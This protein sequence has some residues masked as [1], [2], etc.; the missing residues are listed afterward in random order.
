[1]PDN[2]FYVQPLGG[3]DV[4]QAMDQVKDIVKQRKLE[5]AKKEAARVL[6]TEDPDQIYDFVSANPEFVDFVKQSIGIKNDITQKNLVD[7]AKNI[8]S[9]GDPEQF[10]TERVN[11]VTE[12]GGNPRNTQRA[13]DKYRALKDQVGEEEAKAQTVQKAKNDLALFAPAEYA[14]YRKALGE[15]GEKAK[16]QKTGAW[17]VKDNASG[18]Q[19]VVT[20]VFDPNTG[21]IRTEAGELGDVQLVSQLGEAPEEITQR[22]IAEKQGEVAAK[23][24]EERTTELINRGV[25]AAE[26]TAPIRRAIDLLDTVKTGG[27]ANAALRAKQLFGIESGDEGQLSNLMG[28]AVLSQLRSTFGAAFTESEGKRLMR[29]EANFGKSPETNRKLLKQALS[30]AKMTA[31][32]AREAA[33]KRGDMDTVADIDNLLTFSLSDQEQT[34]LKPVDSMSQEEAIREFLKIIGR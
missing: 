16:F 33:R 4:G 25:T 32:R 2:P 28:K 17:L 29:I 34:A 22:K 30:V 21:K 11:I 24:Q 8:I 15:S 3:F 9:G 18:Q 12:Q 14:S 1:M 20:G 5:N 27:F 13:L 31:K 6:G 23:G 7:T 26:S 10:L 19:K